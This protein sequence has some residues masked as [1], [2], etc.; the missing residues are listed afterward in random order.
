MNFIRDMAPELT[1]LLFLIG[2]SGAFLLTF[3][4]SR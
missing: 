2:M 4:L 1:V 3:V